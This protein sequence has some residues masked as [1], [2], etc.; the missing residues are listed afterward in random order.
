MLLV[1]VLCVAAAFPGPDRFG[2]SPHGGFW[3]GGHHGYDGH[4]HG[5]EHEHHG[6]DG[7]GHHWHPHWHHYWHHH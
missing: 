6:I 5:Y 2:R 4:W 3:H 7:H 1:A